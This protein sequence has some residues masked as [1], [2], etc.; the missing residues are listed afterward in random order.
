[1]QY[2]SVHLHNTVYWEIYALLIFCEMM[3]HRDFVEKNLL[4]ALWQWFT[5]AYSGTWSGT[6]IQYRVLC[7]W[8]PHLQ[9]QLRTVVLYSPSSK[10]CFTAL[11]AASIV[12]DGTTTDSG[13]V[14]S[15]T[16]G[17]PVSPL[18]WNIWIKPFLCHVCLH[19]RPHPHCEISQM[20]NLQFAR[21]HEI[22]K[23]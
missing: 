18:G 9:V 7:S 2:S 6:T 21:I 23:I 1:M 13:P 3:V 4:I 8:F 5:Y 14:G 19:D 12:E 16:T 20:K 22:C 15:G 17:F 10:T 11:F